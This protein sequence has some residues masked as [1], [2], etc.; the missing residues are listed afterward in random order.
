M[1][2][3]LSKLQ[4][5]FGA[6]TKGDWSLKK[7]DLSLADAIQGY[8]SYGKMFLAPQNNAE[9]IS[10]VGTIGDEM[11]EVIREAQTMR[12]YCLGSDTSTENM[13]RRFD[14]ALAALKAKV[15]DNGD[16]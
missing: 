9:F 10:L 13:L 8:V 7:Q 11:L 3:W 14:A 2:D 12:I 4:S 5:V 16:E 15:G 6:R 1:T